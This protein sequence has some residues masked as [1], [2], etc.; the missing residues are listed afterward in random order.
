MNHTWLIFKIAN[1]IV[2]NSISK[3]TIA[4]E[5]TG[6]ALEQCLFKIKNIFDENKVKYL[7]LYFIKLKRWEIKY[8]TSLVI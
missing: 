6:D 1:N 3:D 8:I 4:L 7:L 5:F 2:F